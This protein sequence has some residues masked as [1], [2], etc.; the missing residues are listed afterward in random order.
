MA[1][2]THNYSQFPNALYQPHN[3]KDAD[4][5]VSAY[6]NSIKNSM[7]AGNYA[8]AQRTL[9]SNRAVLE[10][11]TLRAEHLNAVEE[12]LRNMEIY[13]SSQKQAVYYSDTEPGN[14][15]VNDVWIGGN[16]V[17]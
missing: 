7:R 3:F 5:S 9:N 17:V 11:Y 13:A 6:V 8:E 12:E 15:S 1:T 16:A 2:Y 14:P 4:N 10:P